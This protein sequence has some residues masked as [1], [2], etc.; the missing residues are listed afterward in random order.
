METRPFGRTGLTVPALGLGA[1]PLGDHHLSEGDAE[2]LIHAALDLGVTLLDT[3]RSYGASEPRIGRAL[4]GRRARAVLSTKVGY[5]VEGAAD[6]TPEAVR[7][8]IDEAL[9]KLG[10]DWI[11]IVHLH[12]CPEELVRAGDLTGVL[13]A[14]VREGKIRVAAYSGENGALDAAV[15]HGAFSSIELSMSP[16]DQGAIDR[17]LWRAKERGMGAIAKRPLANAWWRHP[18]RPPRPD[19]AEYWDR[20]RALSLPDFGLA[21]EA[22]ALRFAAFTWGIDCA[23]AGTTSLDHL[24]ALAGHVADGPLPGEVT[25]AVR[26]A[27]RRAGAGWPGVV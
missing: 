10:T 1:G 11:D 4:R 3:A 21:P 19:V 15:A 13:T 23:I 14:A 25:A 7:R 6:W 26:D 24:A 27:W 5:G 8:G 20:G 22:L 18:V 17:V 12:S 2:R 9:A 16:W